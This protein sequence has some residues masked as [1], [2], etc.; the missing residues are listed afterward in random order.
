VNTQD[1]KRHIRAHLAYWVPMLGLAG[2]SVTI[3]WH[4]P[5]G[6]G[7]NRVA[8]VCLPQPAVATVEIA[9]DLRAMTT[10]GYSDRQTEETVVHE[11]LH[12]VIVGGS[13][14]ATNTVAHVLVELRRRPPHQW[15][16]AA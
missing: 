7:R 4:R 6:V 5:E 8:A 13:E 10:R 14:R 11:L 1:M 15:E 12:A 2:W 9:F 3:L 16:E